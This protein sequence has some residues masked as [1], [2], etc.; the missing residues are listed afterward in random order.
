[1][2]SVVHTFVEAKKITVEEAEAI[3]DQ[4]KQGYEKVRRTHQED[5]KKENGPS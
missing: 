5:T 1:V 3:K 2:N 4:L